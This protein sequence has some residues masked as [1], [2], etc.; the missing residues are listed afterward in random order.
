M[1]KLISLVIFLLLDVKF[2]YDEICGIDGICLGSGWIYSEGACGILF[3][4]FTPRRILFLLSTVYVIEVSSR[5]G[6]NIKLSVHVA[7]AVLLLLCSAYVEGVCKDGY[8]VDPADPSQ[9][10]GTYFSC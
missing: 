5:M 1:L 10:I 7:V 8:K 9:C 3:L 2:E 6:S 4:R